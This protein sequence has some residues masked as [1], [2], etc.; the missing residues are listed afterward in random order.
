[1]SSCYP[2]ST[3]SN[4]R[5]FVTPGERRTL[6][7]L[8]GG[9]TVRSQKSWQI[10]SQ[11]LRRP[12]LAAVCFPS[13]LWS[14]N[15][16]LTILE[17]LRELLEKDQKTAGQFYRSFVHTHAS[18]APKP[19]ASKIPAR[20]KS[21]PLLSLSLKASYP[22]LDCSIVCAPEDRKAHSEKTGHKFCKRSS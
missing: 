3:A 2:S 14:V 9:L 15:K 20:S 10:L 12:N 7:Q 16:V 18:L 4:F 13:F 5:S 1:V 6:F 22:C 17:H 21:I 8:P 19:I 11:R